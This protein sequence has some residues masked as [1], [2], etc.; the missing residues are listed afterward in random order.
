MTK[1]VY[2]IEVYTA[3]VL[4]HTITT[5][6]KQ[7]M[8]KDSVTDSIGHFSFTVP[9]VKGG[10]N[11]YDDIA[12]NDKIKI[13][14]DYTSVSG[15]PDFIG[16]VYKIDSSYSEQGYLRTVSGLSQ[17]EILLRRHKTDTLWAAVTVK[18]LAD[19]L[20]DDLSL[21]KGDIAADATVLTVEIE[22]KT[23][24]DL[25]RE[26]S[27]YYVSGGSQIKKDFLV[28]VDFDLVFVNRGSSPFATYAALTLEPGV[29]LLSYVVSQDK[30]PVKNNITVYGAKE[31]TEPADI[32]LWA[33][34]AGSPPAGWTSVTGTL[35]QEAVM[36]R[37]GTY[38]VKCNDAGNT[39]DFHKDFTTKLKNYN[40]L[41]FWCRPAAIPVTTKVVRILC[42]DTSNYYEA[43]IQNFNS[44]V[45]NHNELDIGPEHIYDVDS[46]P[47]GVWTARD[48][49]DGGI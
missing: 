19:E 37:K 43:T 44:G 20:A 12:L 38:A 23:Y 6:A 21:G 47:S 24:F 7:I 25:L 32:D 18:T 33:E 28:D 4:D 26:I 27:D 15:D 48:R 35:T 11:S 13:W 14:I 22:T 8:Y 40:K 39:V 30:T 42:P 9:S 3:A 49:L 36:F 1:P 41:T 31:R 2:K 46:N 17:G 34:P 10:A 45:F 29:N 16:R 5:D